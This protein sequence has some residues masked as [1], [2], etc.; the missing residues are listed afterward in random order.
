MRRLFK[1]SWGR[2]S[3]ARTMP[4]RSHRAS[5]ERYSSTY[6]QRPCSAAWRRCS[7]T[8]SL[9]SQ[10]S[11]GSSTSARGKW[12]PYG[13]PQLRG[14]L[15][16]AV[17]AD[18][19]VG[20]HGGVQV[21]QQLGGL[22]VLFQ[23]GVQAEVRLELVEQADEVRQKQGPGLGHVPQQLPGGG[24]H[25]LLP[26]GRV[27]GEKELPEGLHNV[28]HVPGLG[29]GDGAAPAVVVVKGPGAH[30]PPGGSGSPGRG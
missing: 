17:G 13:L 8:S 4:P 12:R 28:H 9:S 20:H 1:R 10:L 19:H 24:V 11:P 16:A 30:S 18:E 3:G 6:C 14:Q 26:V 7:G 25:R 27:A 21:V 29:G 5:K 15:P 23:V 2:A 22:P